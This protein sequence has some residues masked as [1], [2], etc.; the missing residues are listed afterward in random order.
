MLGAKQDH[1]RNGRGEK[2]QY[3]VSELAASM[4]MSQF[5]IRTENKQSPPIL[6]SN[7]REA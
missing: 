4:G 5:L 3:V 1:T 6:V 2:G 7:F